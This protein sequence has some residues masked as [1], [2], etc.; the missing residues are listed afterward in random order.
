MSGTEAFT[1]SGWWMAIH[2]S[3]DWWQPILPVGR[4]RAVLNSGFV[5]KVLEGW[6]WA[7]ITTLQS[8]H[9]FD[10]FGN[11]DSEHTGFSGRLDMVGNPALP[12]GHAKNETGVSWDAFALAPYG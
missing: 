5:G 12:S 11:R 3:R 10:L 8:G 6:Q 1:S 9:P 7:G 2:L 4:G